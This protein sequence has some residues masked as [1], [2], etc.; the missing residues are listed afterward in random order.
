MISGAQICTKRVSLNKDSCQT[1]VS[2]REIFNFLHLQADVY[3]TINDV[4]YNYYRPDTPL[5]LCTEYSSF[6]CCNEQSELPLIVE[7]FRIFYK[8]Q[9]EE[10]TVC[11]QYVR[12]LLC[13]VRYSIMKSINLFA[14]LLEIF[15]PKIRPWWRYLKGKPFA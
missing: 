8:L 5:L 14:S 7:F 11:T 12:T 4:P 1:G 3:Q 2:M 10:R 9:Q 6:G 15:F 13:Q